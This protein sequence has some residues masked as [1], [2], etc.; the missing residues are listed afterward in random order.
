MAHLEERELIC[1]SCRRFRS[2]AEC[3]GR[4]MDH[5]NT[6]LFCSICGREIKTP[7]CCSGPMSVRY[8]VRNIKKEIFRN[9]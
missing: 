8:K 4:P 5:D 9:L 6:V 2:L 3:C 7:L 1:S